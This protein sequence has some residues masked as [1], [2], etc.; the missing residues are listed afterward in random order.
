EIA[1]HFGPD[2]AGYEVVQ[3]AID[4]MT[5]VA[6]YINDMKR[7]H[8]HAVR[9]QE[10]QSLLINWKG[11]DLTTYGELVLEGTFHVL[12]AKNSRTLFLFEKMLL[13][14]KRRGEHYVYKTHISCST[15]MLLDSAK[16]PLLFSVIHFRHPKQPHTVQAK[17]AIVDNSN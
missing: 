9:V 13:I 7:K 12:R 14:T 3:E 5:G 1:K 16:D 11:P 2:E 10:I 4:T 15:L 8:E 17:E 6:W